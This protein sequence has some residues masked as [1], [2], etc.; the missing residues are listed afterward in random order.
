MTDFTL[1]ASN[2]SDTTRVIAH[3]VQAKHYLTEVCWLNTDRNN[4]AV[5]PSST[6]EEFMIDTG[7]GGLTSVIG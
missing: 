1:I 4:S 5:I 7:F 3:T 2:A 6:T